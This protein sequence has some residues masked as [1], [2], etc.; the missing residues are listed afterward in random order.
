[1]R[2][3]GEETKE[4]HK[5]SFVVLAS[6]YRRRALALAFRR[7]EGVGAFS[8]SC[9]LSLGDDWAFASSHGA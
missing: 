5:A 3:K 9:K 4:A 1:V 2:R 6:G 7:S 8:P